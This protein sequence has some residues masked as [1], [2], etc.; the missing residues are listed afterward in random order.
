MMTIV[1]PSFFPGRFDMEAGG[2]LHQKS[3]ILGMQRDKF[4][5]LTMG[6]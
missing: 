1:W 5:T 4:K 6:G 2:D 3:P